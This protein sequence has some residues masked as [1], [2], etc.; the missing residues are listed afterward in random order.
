MVFLLLHLKFNYRCAGYYNT[1]LSYCILDV[2]VS[3]WS[4]ICVIASQ[5]GRAVNY[6]HHL[7]VWMMLHDGMYCEKR[8]LKD[9][10]SQMIREF[11]RMLY[12]LVLSESTSQ[13]F[14]KHNCSNVCWRRITAMLVVKWSGKAM[15]FN[16]AKGAT[17]NTESRRKYLQRSAH[18]LFNMK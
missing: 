14:H 15:K 5:M 13:K 18:Q 10:K 1:C 8:G 4:I 11:S 6:L 3:H 9:C 2:I 7:G 12:L 17:I 16:T